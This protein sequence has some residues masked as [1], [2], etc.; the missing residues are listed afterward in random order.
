MTTL[1]HGPP[2]AGGI[3][4]F[5]NEVEMKII[6]MTG[7]QRGDLIVRMKMFDRMRMRKRAI[8]LLYMAAED[9]GNSGD[10]NEAD[11]IR[12][13]TAAIREKE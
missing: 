7:E 6:A 1:R 10:H 2:K 8:E 4:E 9:L 11:K 5:I 13:I 12:K 3:D